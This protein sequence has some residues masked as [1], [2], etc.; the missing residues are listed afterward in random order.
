[1]IVGGHNKK[2]DSSKLAPTLVIATSSIL[3]NRTA[4]WPIATNLTTSLPEWEAEIERSMRIANLVLSHA[5][6]KSPSL[7]QQKDVPWYM[8]SE[9]ESP[10]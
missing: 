2:V 8:P 5:L 10:E 1:M 6:A 9:D 4:R 3:A 7:F